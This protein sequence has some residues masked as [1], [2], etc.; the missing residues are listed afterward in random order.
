MRPIDDNWSQDIIK[1]FIT[2]S[3]LCG[4]LF[5]FKQFCSSHFAHGFD[6]LQVFTRSCQAFVITSLDWQK[7]YEII[8][9]EKYFEETLSDLTH[10]DRENACDFAD[11]I[12]K[13][14]F[15][16]ENVEIFISVSL[17][18][19]PKS[20]IENIPAL[21][22]IMAWRQTGDKPLSETMMA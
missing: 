4:Q 7:L 2:V 11:N 3:L 14:T 13:C 12:F 20:P 10:W 17:K 1:N 19:V 21:V 6:V 8:D 5:P 15:L 16:N 22:Q 9:M 18:F